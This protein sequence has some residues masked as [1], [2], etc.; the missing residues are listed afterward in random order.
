M[1]V[2]EAEWLGFAGLS[3]AM[4]GDGI[5]VQVAGRTGRRLA[6]REQMMGG[7]GWVIVAVLGEAING[8]PT[9]DLKILAGG[10][11]V[12]WLCGHS[13]NEYTSA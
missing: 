8:K 4:L 10:R 11:M 2:G 12:E 3:G 1:S 7:W 13:V 6:N 5:S 9:K